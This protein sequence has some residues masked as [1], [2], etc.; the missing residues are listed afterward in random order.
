[1]VLGGM[2]AI[3]KQSVSLPTTG[4]FLK[5][6]PEN[7]VLTAWKRSEADPQQWI[8]RCYEAHG[9]SAQFSIQSS[10][11]ALEQPQR[12]DL[13]EN[14]MPRSHLVPDVDPEL[15]KLSIQPWQVC[16]FRINEGQGIELKSSTAR[17]VTREI[18]HRFKT[19]R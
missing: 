19:E 5:P 11:L 12:L 14:P 7:V 4:Q 17:I 10:M 2:N 9:Q 6:W 3:A 16:T 18:I 15:G 8:L 1:M 13:L